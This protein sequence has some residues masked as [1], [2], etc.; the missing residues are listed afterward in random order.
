MDKY[1][2][3]VARL[4]ANPKLIYDTWNNYRSILFESLPGIRNCLTE[5]KSCYRPNTGIGILVHGVVDE[6]LTQEL[7]AD[8]NIPIDV[9][10]NPN[11][12]KVEMLPHFAN[13][14]RRIAQLNQ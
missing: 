1:D 6:R 5:I 7:L 8:C 9:S 3:E 14:Q 11:A 10:F 13:W 2:E 4:T 12:I